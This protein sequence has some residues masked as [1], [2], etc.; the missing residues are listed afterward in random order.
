MTHKVDHL[1]IGSGI[2]GLM[3]AHKLGQKDKVTVIAKSKIIDNNTNY[4]QVA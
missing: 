4:A 1:I 2:A 3:L